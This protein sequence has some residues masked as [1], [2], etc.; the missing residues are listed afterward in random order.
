MNALFI[1]ILSLSLS[2]FLSLQALTEA[3]AEILENQRQLEEEFCQLK[4]GGGGG[5][6]EKN[7][8]SKQNMKGEIHG[9]TAAAQGNRETIN[10]S[11]T[12]TCTCIGNIVAFEMHNYY[13]TCKGY[14]LQ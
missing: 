5:G 1:L 2:L 8:S 10:I 12:C 11:T 14:T 3:L 13:H 6:G 9:L 4:S 7:D